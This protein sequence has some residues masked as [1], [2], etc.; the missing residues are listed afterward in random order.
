[1]AWFN[2]NWQY[3]APITSQSNEITAAVAN[4]L[5]IDL[6]AHFSAVSDFWDNIKSDGG[7]IRITKADGTTE[8]ARGVRNIDTVSE[9]GILYVHH[10]DIS[11]STDVTIYI[12]WG[13]A[14]A[15]D[16]ADNALNGIEDIWTGET[17][18]EWYLTLDDDDITGSTAN[19][20][21]GNNHDGTLV[22]AP[23]SIAGKIGQGRS[24]NLS[25]PDIIT[26]PHSADFAS[27]TALTMM[28]W[29]KRDNV[30]QGAFFGRV[31]SKP[32][33]GTGDDYMFGVAPNG[34]NYSTIFR[35]TAGTSTNLESAENNFPADTWV[36]YTATWDGSTMETYVDGVSNNSAAK[37]GTLGQSS[38]E[39]GIGAHP[40][41]LS[42]SS[43]RAFDGSIDIPRFYSRS[44]SSEEIATIF[45]NENANAS[46]WSR[47]AVELFSDGISVPSATLTLTGFAP[48]VSISDKHVFV[49][50]AAELQ[51]SASSPNAETVGAAVSDART[52]LSWINRLDDAVATGGSGSDTNPVT[53][54]QN[55][56]VSLLYRSSAESVT[57]DFDLGRAETMQ[58]FALLNTSIGASGTVEIRLSNVAPGGVDVMDTGAITAA[59]TP[60]YPN[61]FFVTRDQ[62]SARYVQFT[63][64]NTGID[65][66]SIGRAWAG[67]AYVPTINDAFGRDV[68]WIDS[69]RKGKNHAG[70][71]RSRTGKTAR[72]FAFDIPHNS[73]TEVFANLNSMDLAIG[74]SGDLV[75]MLDRTNYALEFSAIGNI[76]RATP[77]N[78][79]DFETAA[80]R[81]VFEERL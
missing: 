80:K 76:V 75:V 53:N 61:F 12:Y 60:R 24:F 69:G 71:V 48:S 6:A 56:P 45:S 62:F 34:A 22:S 9:T 66:V 20:I 74:T 43:G 37:S 63:I 4:G 32:N 57:I 28:C 17:A 52:I 31:I 44:L 47:G 19:D 16:H 5:I 65:T 72:T 55:N 36:H 78:R 38:Q 49:P 42:A 23:G 29:I 3:R 67:P 68:A 73:P 59:T 15:T 70:G 11:T 30:A 25:D 10:E 39:F 8:L 40:N 2:N 27:L 58:L 54:I 51:L 13:N 77:I 33:A 21:S 41:D 81:I 35:L 64:V 1:M 26:I 18:I 7:D 79:P 50:P 46:F 14:S